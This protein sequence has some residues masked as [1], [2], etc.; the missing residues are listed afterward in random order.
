MLKRVGKCYTGKGSLV[1]SWCIISSSRFC[2]RQGLYYFH[3]LF[4]GPASSTCSLEFIPK[5]RNS[6][7]FLKYLN[8]VTAILAIAQSPAPKLL[9]KKWIKVPQEPISRN[10]RAFQTV[11]SILTV[12]AA[13]VRERVKVYILKRSKKSLCV[14]ALF[15]SDYAYQSLREGSG[16]E[17]SQILWKFSFSSFL[18][19]YACSWVLGKVVVGN[20]AEVLACV[21]YGTI[22]TYSIHQTYTSWNIKID[23]KIFARILYL[24]KKFPPV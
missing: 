18:T 2:Q 12:T 17:L 4:P 11:A 9:E 6:E 23:F 19:V 13:K 5:K 14:L 10:S 20:L 16:W 22:F 15:F 3:I 7:R 21:I 1:I 8:F 24:K